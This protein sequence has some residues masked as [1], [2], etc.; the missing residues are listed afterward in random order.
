[1]HLCVHEYILRERLSDTFSDLT[2]LRCMRKELLVAIVI[3][4]FFGIIIG[5]GIWRANNA[6]SNDQISTEA[7]PTE[8]IMQ[9][10]DSG[11]ANQQEENKPNTGLVISTP[12]DYD[13]ITTPTTTIKGLA[14][15][16]SKV[17]VSAESKD[18]ITTTGANGD[19]EVSIDLINGLNQIYAQE[20]GND[21]EPLVLKVVFTKDL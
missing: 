14:S 5:F 3:G 15:P 21:S 17:V 7:T 12:S 18:Y 11:S 13:V 9:E 1:M 4:L 20:L 19:F 6:I 16:N 2:N 8:Q 10:S